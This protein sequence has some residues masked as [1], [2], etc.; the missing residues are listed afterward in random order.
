MVRWRDPEGRAC[1]TGRIRPTGAASMGQS[2]IIAFPVHPAP[3]YLLGRDED[4]RW[5][6]RDARG[7][8]G[9]V[10]VDRNAA[11]RFANHET[12]HR[13][14][15]VHAVPEPLRLTLTGALPQL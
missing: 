2:A 8:V 11:L 1:G 10:F 14:N 6:V 9:G 3:D 7:L 5:I 12:D 13:P 15:A 4:G